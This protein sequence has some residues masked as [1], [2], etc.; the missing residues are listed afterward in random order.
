M[1]TLMKWPGTSCFTNDLAKPRVLVRPFAPIEKA[2][3]LISDV[4]ELW[5]S[6]IAIPGDGTDIVRAAQW[7]DEKYVEQRD[8]P[9]TAD[10]LRIVY[11]AAN[12]QPASHIFG[13]RLGSVGQ[14]AGGSLRVGSNYRIDI[15]PSTLSLGGNQLNIVP[16]NGTRAPHE[17]RRNL[18]SGPSPDH[19]SVEKLWITITGENAG[20]ANARGRLA[21]S[22]AAGKPSSLVLFHKLGL[23]SRYNEVIE[24]TDPIGGGRHKSVQTI[25]SSILHAGGDFEKVGLFSAS[26]DPHLPYDATRS[27]FR[28]LPNDP[29]SGGRKAWRTFK[30]LLRVTPVTDCLEISVPTGP[31]HV[32]QVRPPN[33]DWEGPGAPRFAIT[34]HPSR[35][36]DPE[37]S[38][39]EDTLSLIGTFE[40]V[41]TAEEN[42]RLDAAQLGMVPGFSPSETLLPW[43]KATEAEEPVYLSFAL[44]PAYD[45]RIKPEAGAGPIDDDTR[46]ELEAG[47]Q[48]HERRTSWMKVHRSDQR[49]C[50]SAE[51]PTARRL[52]FDV[53]SPTGQAVLRHEPIYREAVSTSPEAVAAEQAGYL[54]ILPARGVLPDRR[55]ACANFD[56]GLLSRERLK[57]TA[58]SQTQP[59]FAKSA[60][61]AVATTPLGFDMETD[62]T[63]AVTRI[64]FARAKVDQVD[65]R[66]GVAGFP[67]GRP[68]DSKMLDALVRN[69]LFLVANRMPLKTD[70]PALVFENE[71]EIAGWKFNVLIDAPESTSKMGAGGPPKFDTFFLVKNHAAKSIKELIDDPSTWCGKDLF[72]TDLRDPEKPLPGSPVEQ[73]RKRI[74]DFIGTVEKRAHDHQ[75]IT[76]DRQR[77]QRLYNEILADPDWQGVLVI[78]ASLG[79]GELPVQIKGLLGGLDTSRLKAE[80]VAVP[81]KALASGT[82]KP[83]SRLQALVDYR[84]S[85]LKN[86]DPSKPPVLR[87]DDDQLAP[88]RQSYGYDVERLVVEFTR[89]EVLG[90]EARVRLAAER[91]FHAIGKIEQS[92][93]SSEAYKDAKFIALNG[94]YE[95]RRD[96]DKVVE[97]YVFETA[98]KYRYVNSEPGAIIKQADLKRIAYE[99]LAVDNATGKVDAAFRI[100][101][102]IKFGRISGGDRLPDLPDL[103]DIEVIDFGDLRIGTLFDLIGNAVANLK[104]S[105]RVGA[106]GFDFPNA[107]RRA[108]DERGFWSSF[109][110]KFRR[111]WMFDGKQ[112]LGKLGYFGFSG[113]DPNLDFRFGFDFDLDLGTLGALSSFKGLRIGVLFA[114]LDGGPSL[115]DG[116]V[117]RFTLGF[118]FPEGDG[119]LDIG[120]QGFLKL[121]AKQYGILDS[122]YKDGA[123]EKAAKLMYAVAARLE[124]LGKDFPQDDGLTVA[125]FVD[126]AKLQSSGITTGAVGWFA[127]RRPAEDAQ[128]VVPGV[129][130]ELLAI[131]QRVD[132]IRNVDVT[133]TK[134][135]TDSLDKLFLPANNGAPGFEGAD[136]TD[137]KKAVEKIKKVL[138][139]GRIGF[140]PDRN[141]SIGFSA[142]FAD[143]VKIGLA[144]RDADI[145]GLRV[146]LR[147][148]KTDTESIFAID[149]LYRKLSER[150]GVYSIEIVPPAS[151]R[152]IDFGAVTIDLPNIGLEIFTDGGFT[153]D[154]GFPWNMNY[155]RAFGVQV[156][157]FI[158]SGGVYYRQVSGPGA[159]LV[160]FGVKFQKPGDTKL[161][162]EE[163][164]LKYFP[165]VEAGIA[166][167]VGLGK[168]IDKGIFRAGLSLTV[169]ATLEG[170]FGVLKRGPDFVKEGLTTGAS[171]SF[172]AVRGL[173]G[174]MGEIYGFVDFGIVKA[175]VSIRLWVAYGFEFK[176][177]HRTRLYI[178]VGVNVSVS[179]VIARIRIFGRRIEISIS[180]SFATTVEFSTYLGNDRNA[181]YY[182]FAAH[183]AAA[184]IEAR[185]GPYFDRPPITEFRWAQDV[186]PEHWRGKADKLAFDLR[187]APDVTLAPSDATMQPEAVLMLVAPAPAAAGDIDA[188][189]GLLAVWAFAAAYKLPTG[190]TLRS[191]KVDGFVLDELSRKLAQGPLSNSWDAARAGVDLRKH[192]PTAGNIAELFGKN[193]AA[194]FTILPKDTGAGE[195]KREPGLFWPIP[196]GS[197][198]AR[199]R[200]SGHPAFNDIVLGDKRVVNDAY[201]DQVDEQLR[202]LMALLEEPQSNGALA[203]ESEPAPIAIAETIFVEHAILIMRAAL[204]QLSKLADAALA[205]EPPGSQVELGVLLD[206]LSAAAPTGDQSPARDILH[207]ATRLFLHGPRLP[208][209]A[210]ADGDVKLVPP[211]MVK[212]EDHYPLYRLG[213]LQVPL[214][215][216]TGAPDDTAITLSIATTFGAPATLEI[217]GINVGELEA[218]SALG[219]APAS[220]GGSLLVLEPTRPKSR[221][222]HAG[223]VQPIETGGR[224]VMLNTQILDVLSKA[225]EDKDLK[226]ALRKLP[227]RGDTPI[228]PVDGEAFFATAVPATP[229]IAVRVRLAPRRPDGA[230][231]GAP[232]LDVFEIRGMSEAN[233]VRLDRFED[234]ENAQEI[235]DIEIYA[236]NDAALRNLNAPRDTTVVQVDVSEE[237]QPYLEPDVAAVA[238]PV[239]ATY[240]AT[241]ETDESRAAFIDIVRRTGIVNRGGTM[242][243]WEGA[244][245]AFDRHA[246]DEMPFDAL[247]VVKLKS[248]MLAHANA[249][250]ISKDDAQEAG[251]V[252][253]LEAV[254]KGSL[255]AVNDAVTV[256]EPVADAGVLPLEISRPL[257][258]KPAGADQRQWQE[259]C[260][261]FS[262]FA[263]GVRDE[264]G[265]LILSAARSLAVGPTDEDDSRTDND[266]I[267]ISLPLAVSKIFRDASPYAS[268]GRKIK[269]DGVWR[270]IYGND[271]I[272]PAF[273]KETIEV[274]YVDRLVPLTDLPGLAFAWWPTAKAAAVELRFWLE[275]RWAEGLVPPPS[276]GNENIV[277]DDIT[278]AAIRAHLERTRALYTRTMQQLE[279]D[280]KTNNVSAALT[281]PFA[282][283]QAFWSA[284]VAL[285]TRPISVLLQSILNVVGELENVDLAQPRAAIIADFTKRI[286]KVSA[287]SV[288]IAG[289]VGANDFME[290]SLALTITRNRHHHPNATQDMK[291]VTVPVALRLREDSAVN[292]SD[293]NSGFGGTLFDLQEI[294]R[295]GFAK[296]RLVATGLSTR[297]DTGD[298]VVWLVARTV[299]PPL[300]HFAK[301]KGP[302]GLRCFATPPISTHL[303]SFE[304]L[305]VPQRDGTNKPETFRAIDADVEAAS[306]LE[307]YEQILKPD[308]IEKFQRSSEGREAMQRIVTAKAGVQGTEE[309]D[310]IATMLSKRAAEIYEG[311]DSPHPVKDLAKRV[312][313][314]RAMGSLTAVDA[315]DTVVVLAD[316]NMHDKLEENGPQAYGRFTPS[317]ADPVNSRPFVMT[318]GS[319]HRRRDLV[320]TLD[321]DPKLDKASV[322][323]AGTYRITHVQRLARP[324]KGV[325]GQPGRYRPTAWLALLPPRYDKSGSP[326]VLDYAIAGDQIPIVRRRYPAPP[327]ILSEIVEPSAQSPADPFTSKTREWQSNR[328]WRAEARGVDLLEVA[329]RYNPTDR[330]LDVGN[331][332]SKAESAWAEAFIV[333][334][335]ATIPV[336]RAEKTKAPSND[337]RDLAKFLRERCESLREALAHTFARTV[338]LPTDIVDRLFLVETNSNG[339][340]VIDV[341]RRN[342]PPLLVGTRLTLSVV[343]KDAKTDLASK[344]I[345]QSLK[346]PSVPSTPGEIQIRRLRNA[347]VDILAL[348]AVQTELTL[349][350]NAKI[351]EKAVAKSFVYRVPT[352]ASGS[353]LVPR[354]DVNQV[355]LATARA[356]FDVHVRSIV[357]TLLSKPAG[358]EDGDY[359]EILGQL[360]LDIIVTFEPELAVSVD[361]TGDGLHVAGLCRFD[362]STDRTQWLSGFIA[363][364]A[365]WLARYSPPAGTFVFDIRLYERIVPD[366]GST[367][368]TGRDRLIL[369]IRRGTL[370]LKLVN[371]L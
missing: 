180:F 279:D 95:R 65:V 149:V 220:L 153:I 61:G 299:F 29:S 21:R 11:L 276:S 330:L 254:I 63:G 314:D 70:M 8:Q 107:K 188:V 280:L 132:P 49:M 57:R 209:P 168:E 116:K 154:L 332:P 138:T 157:P 234:G 142:W 320:F 17:F 34:S 127:A 18:A 216:P 222:F 43:P 347:R 173:V 186:R 152:Q 321:A 41:R 309:I 341:E 145:Y 170:G 364:A 184:Q 211:G 348:R 115:V 248:E 163:D 135:F 295:K 290:L 113:F 59:S 340:R 66:F 39:P 301:L 189:P 122:K 282:D 78:G 193:I 128:E 272:V 178:Q 72:V 371:Q 137:P 212:S 337:D 54:P 176:T 249:M 67:S 369:R 221:H 147:K 51:A 336:L 363:E 244:R 108:S 164:Q 80:Y 267:R 329:L 1:V 6:I 304:D 118:R 231:Q 227:E 9:V 120:I 326:W 335:R 302:D 317:D 10:S 344:E 357:E 181:E 207:A 119:S 141:W 133:T 245:I 159:R 322:R 112:N 313:Q 104:M 5:S 366:A 242:L 270:D 342:P 352:V 225:K 31:G 310:G 235:E 47:A 105:F 155:A 361:V 143:R 210:L 226:L 73:T 273:E 288:E 91:L 200:L 53:T 258:A 296:E 243:G 247:I 223:R 134:S 250:L 206:R 32:L 13:N 169:F 358:L 351:D 214:G 26:L 140:A 203:A 286:G 331:P 311:H 44:G 166:F 89:G 356:G 174:V 213:W 323:L 139:G 171:N 217:T 167:R 325:I 14:R 92:P 239:P 266:E 339:K 338:A 94:R 355:P 58:I 56:R 52:A 148:T 195:P 306:A 183:A 175:G 69:K 158:G 263:Y 308:M 101:G 131:G 194:T 165:V 316:P 33:G 98:D 307:A 197:R 97:N 42:G 233:R 205:S 162:E 199:T 74:L 196:P 71:I 187:F 106:L 28:V 7:L 327:E 45:P 240:V 264:K 62:A 367:K 284:P 79:L 55:K 350:R 30:R 87:D 111:F 177:D 198:I 294:V 241:L 271:W 252:D 283:A 117:P 99:T 110:L 202:Q 265:T 86:Y 236:I 289:T 219:A 257:P 305:K 334:A 218:F 68:I 292:L 100:D 268:I 179:V 360:A 278:Q 103:F 185:A 129:D 255:P 96:G 318:V 76:D 123:E 35:D 291:S 259:L 287:T 12:L 253:R 36:S 64:V 191:E 125:L 324:D 124:V 359:V 88:A 328:I 312:L 208:W 362:L 23:V 346:W 349:M 229:A 109:P 37:T 77:Y 144:V 297:P 75:S 353:K 293:P 93:R 246:D 24:K 20:L 256:S 150:L 114:F 281:A 85:D 300:D 237:P 4:R 15:A 160:P 319:K 19:A 22:N 262:M 275:H 204:T 81:M 151:L 60:F 285:D 269:I 40:L 84:L 50:L 261:R 48:P 136:E 182:R 16:N 83:V 82:D 343:D 260:A 230:A 156:L 277:L 3:W 370:P 2:Q 121:K 172:I 130:L 38:G 190:A 354:V 303:H 333:F 102:S 228:A 90:F 345:A 224:L 368:E 365:G 232:F 215:E 27:Y 46:P 315:I 298:R 126:P 238:E 146:D 192:L 251:D 274:T 25:E 201:R 161:Y